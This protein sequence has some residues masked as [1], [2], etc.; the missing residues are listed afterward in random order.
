[1]FILR[2]DKKIFGLIGTVFKIKKTPFIRYF[3]WWWK[4]YLL[5]DETFLFSI[6]AKH[7]LYAVCGR[8]LQPVVCLVIKLTF[9]LKK[10]LQDS[11]TYVNASISITIGNCAVLYRCTIH[12]ELLRYNR[13][14]I[15]QLHRDF[16]FN[17]TLIRLLC[18]PL[19]L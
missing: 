16:A 4:I 7:C 12:S 19:I 9:S 11:C 3:F 18:I 2:K 1:M 15:S 8:R 5:L 17:Q 13:K 10:P 14:Y 6:N